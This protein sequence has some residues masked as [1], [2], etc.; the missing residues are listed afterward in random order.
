MNPIKLAL[1]TPVRGSDPWSSHVTVGYSE[2]VRLLH[3]TLPLEEV[4]ATL[5]FCADVVR[6][7][8][9]IVAKVLRDMPDVTHVLWIDDDEWT[10]DV[11]VVTRMLATGSDVI[12]A[13]YTN[14]RKPVRWVHQFLNEE[15]KIENGLL[16]VRGLGMGFTLTTRRCLEKLSA[17]AEQYWDLPLPHQVA[18]IFGQL[19]DEAPTGERM[20]LSE[21]FSFCKRWRDSG[22][23]VMIYAGAGGLVM[24]A[25][26]YGWSARDIEGGVK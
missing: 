11:S 23:K 25:G 22:G 14:K 15:P 21:D 24:H 13:G 6:A 3:R 4:S 18:N 8:N 20:L 16:E 17:Q 5:T 19:Y 10:E 26:S 2:F 7:R 1:A 12:G 9:R